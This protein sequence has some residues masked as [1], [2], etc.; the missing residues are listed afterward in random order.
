MELDLLKKATKGEMENIPVKLGKS[1]E[2][3]KLWLEA[4]SMERA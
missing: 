4:E 3:V 1:S 2:P